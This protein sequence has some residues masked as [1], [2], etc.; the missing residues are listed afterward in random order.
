MAYDKNFIRVSQTIYDKD[1][2]LTSK[3]VS[4]SAVSYPDVLGPIHSARGF[5]GG[6][7]IVKKLVIFGMFGL[8]I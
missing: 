6:Y 7:V 2:Q 4:L 3:R 5:R 1:N 8:V